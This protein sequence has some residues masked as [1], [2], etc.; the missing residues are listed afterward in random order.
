MK[1]ELRDI[2]ALLELFQRS[3]AT[4]MF[5]ATPQFEL[6]ASKRK[7]AARLELRGNLNTSNPTQF[8]LPSSSQRPA[9][10]VGSEAQQ[11]LPPKQ[12]TTE[13]PQGHIFVRAANLGTFYRS[14]K[15]GAPPYVNVGDAVVPE[16]EVCLIEVMKLFTPLYAS[17]RGIVREILVNDS[18]LVEFDQ[19]LFLVELRD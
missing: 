15:P 7:Q 9:P 13:A 12:I 11:T 14:P 6:R 10:V 19:P 3:S 8:E 16:A 5:L 18:S 2:D 1:T 4:D 17:V